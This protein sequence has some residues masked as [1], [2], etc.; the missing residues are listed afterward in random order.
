MSLL[1]THQTAALGEPPAGSAGSAER[2][3]LVDL[4]LP[5]PKKIDDHPAIQVATNGRILAINGGPHKDG[6]PDLATVISYERPPGPFAG[7]QRHET[8]VA[9]TDVGDLLI[10]INGGDLSAL[11]P[12]SSSP[13]KVGGASDEVTDD[14]IDDVIDV[15]VCTHGSRDRC[16]G[17]LGARLFMELD[18]RRRHGEWDDRIRVWRTSHIGGHRFAPTAM[19]FPDA[20]GWAWLDVDTI[21]G[22]ADRSLDIV[23]AAEIARG[24]G[25]I[26][27]RAGQIADGRAFAHYGWDWLD[28]ARTVTVDGLD[29]TVESALGSGSIG[30][31][32]GEPIPV[33]ICGE[34]GSTKST[35][36]FEVTRETWSSP[37]T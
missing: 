23:T 4:P 35:P 14:V 2:Y 36:Q 33:P 15:L 7:F 28:T 19:T 18:D 13:S 25:G 10:A 9:P 12:A 31:E 16:C 30:L 8:A 20:M 37:N 24:S 22:I 29:V 1:C 17:N 11:E 21:T 3:I 34:E 32:A 27:S 5:W 26:D 6:D